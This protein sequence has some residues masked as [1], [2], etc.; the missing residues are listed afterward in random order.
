MKALQ[1]LIAIALFLAPAPSYSQSKGKSSER[2]YEKKTSIRKARTDTSDVSA[3]LKDSTNAERGPVLN[4]NGNVNSSGA[5]DGERSNTGRPDA[6]SA[7]SYTVKRT[8]KTIKTGGAI[9]P[10]S[11][12]KSKP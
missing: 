3:I 9:M 7:A 10:D 12:K 11:T 2:V 1:L 8:K 5:V 6:D 4:D